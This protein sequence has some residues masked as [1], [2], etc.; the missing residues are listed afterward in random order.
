VTFGADH[1]Q[2]ISV[3]ADRTVRLWNLDA[4]LPIPAVL[5]GHGASVNSVSFAEGRLFTASTDGTLRTWLLAPEALGMRA[6]TVAGRNL[7]ADEWARY[8]PD[9]PCQPTCSGL[10]DRCGE[11]SP[12]AP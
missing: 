1:T 12:T 8:L 9:M 4:A 10:P 11:A 5:S 6:C 2:L 3:S 7:Y